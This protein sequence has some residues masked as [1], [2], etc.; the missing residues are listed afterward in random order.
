MF[1]GTVVN[2][3]FE[4]GISSRKP[5]FVDNKLVNGRSSTYSYSQVLGK[6]TIREKVV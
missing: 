1:S 5:I 6:G 4:V 2:R 3:A